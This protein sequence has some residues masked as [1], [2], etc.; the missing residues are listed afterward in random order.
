MIE[1]V[2]MTRKETNR[3]EVLMK[4]IQKRMTQAQAAV[5][6]NLSLR[7]VQRPG[8]GGHVLLS[9]KEEGDPIQHAVYCHLLPPYEFQDVNTP[10]FSFKTYDINTFKLYLAKYFTKQDYSEI[11]GITPVV[12]R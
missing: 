8:K 5:E 10:L 2:Y 9:L 1:G 4:V 7:Q 6:L 3:A 12:K 11:Q